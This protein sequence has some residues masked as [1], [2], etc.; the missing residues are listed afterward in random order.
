M[1]LKTLHAILKS[2]VVLAPTK[3]VRYYF[4]GIHFKQDSYGY[5]AIEATDGNHLVQH[6]TDTKL[7]DS[8][9]FILPIEQ[10]KPLLARIELE[11]K[12]YK[13]DNHLIWYKF[14]D[15][16]LLLT[17]D[18]ELKIELTTFIDARYPDTDRVM[19]HSKD[20]KPVDQIGLDA[21]LFANVGKC[22]AP[23]KKKRSDTQPT[24]VSLFGP[25]DAVLF[26]VETKLVGI[27][28][29]KL[30]LMPCRL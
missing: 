22:F 14:S 7:D 28:T 6:V 3:D 10:V 4:N 12:T 8:F 5:L 1:N 23:L 9:N 17:F 20:R 19:K 15:N 27:D 2:C 26:E 24:K 29:A 18:S 13:I 11:L 30:V 21:D 25:T 16:E